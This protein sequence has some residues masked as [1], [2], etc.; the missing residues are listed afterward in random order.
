MASDP[1]IC[2]SCA[3]Q[4]K[5]GVESCQWCGASFAEA[6]STK[7][8]PAMQPPVSRPDVGFG[9][10]SARPLP[11][12]PPPPKALPFSNLNGGQIILRVIIVLAVAYI[13]AVLGGKLIHDAACAVPGS[14]T[15]PDSPGH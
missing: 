8:A 7:V 10:G 14:P 4:L 6:E 15:C 1:E 3:G 13:V 2:P 11:P 9:G 5:P 12:L